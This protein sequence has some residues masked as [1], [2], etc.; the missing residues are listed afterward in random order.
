MVHFQVRASVRSEHALREADL[1]QGR[2]KLAVEGGGG[3]LQ[4]P[5]RAREGLGL[6]IVQQ[7]QQLGNEFLALD[8]PCITAG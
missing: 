5:P 2:I 8:D 6:G 7:C 3:R 1:F 4:M